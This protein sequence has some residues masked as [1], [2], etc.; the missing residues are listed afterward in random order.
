MTM[1]WIVTGALIAGLC[2][3]SLLADNSPM[4][5]TGTWDLS[6]DSKSCDLTAQFGKGADQITLMFSRDMPTDAFDLRLIGRRFA[7]PNFRSDITLDFG[8][9]L[10]PKRATTLNGR[11]GDRPMMLLTSLQLSDQDPDE[12]GTSHISASALAAIDSLTIKLGANSTRLQ[13]GSMAPPMAGLTGCINDMIAE[14]G[15]DPRQ[16]ASLTRRAT[17][18]TSPGDWLNTGDF[19]VK[20]RGRGESGVTRFRLDIDET[21]AVTGCHIATAAGDPAFARA[22]CDGIQKR[23]RFSPALDAQGQPVRSFYVNGVRW[24]ATADE[25]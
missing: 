8:P 24:A 10:A 4:V 14:W 11:F 25:R 23:A 17:P 13:L 20:L 1:R 22:T 16:Q 21:G 12:S 15:F 2:T 6:Y 5:R 7:S 19:P 18:L 3:S 9:T